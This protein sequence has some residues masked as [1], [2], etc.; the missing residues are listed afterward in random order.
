MLDLL[1]K[2]APASAFHVVLWSLLGAIAGFGV[3]AV[4]ALLF[5]RLGAFRLEWRH[6]NWARVLAALWILL[7]AIGGGAAIGSCEGT[8]RGAQRAV[9]DANLRDGPLLS[10][11]N[12]VSAGV[13]WIDL[14]LRNAPE[15]S[16]GRYVKGE[17]KLDVPAFYGRL[18][19]AESDVVDGLVSTWNAQAQARLGLPRSALVDAL[20]GAGLRLVAEKLVRK[21]VHDTAKDVGVASAKDGFFA[22]LDGTTGEHADLSRR[23]LDSCVVP[24]A[25]TPVRIL[26]RGQ[27]LSAALL[28][29]L[30]LLLPVL[31][32][33]I[34]RIVERRKNSTKA[35]AGAILPP[36]GTGT[37]AGTG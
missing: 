31:G 11:A 37:G 23:L 34:G 14:R 15:E 19:K 21:A 24:L 13:A 16:F 3:G 17:E 33:W 18:A 8:W 22:A 1:L 4:A 10:A 5:S 7:A 20:L 2:T 27:Q 6:A 9:A 12:C 30:A 26:V 32:F 29:G 36:A 28:G 35:P 25:L